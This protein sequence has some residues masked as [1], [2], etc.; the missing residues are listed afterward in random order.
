MADNLAWTPGAGATIAT[1]EV[2]TGGGNAHVQLIKL[3]DGTDG[4]TERIQGT[5]A[6][7]LEV[8]VTRVQG[9]VTVAGTVSVTNTTASGLQA[10]VVGTVAH[11][12]AD[13]GKPVKFGLKANS[14]MPAAV[15][16]GQRVDAWGDLYGRQV[17]VQNHPT[18]SAAIAVATAS[19]LTALIASSTGKIILN[20][21]SIHNRNATGTVVQLVDGSSTG[22]AF[23]KGLL[24]SGGGGSLFDFGAGKSLTTGNALYAHIDT[25]GNVD[26][27]LTEYST[28]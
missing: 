24:A 27:N 9:S 11:G 8:D 16:S 7:G 15:S 21:G 1:D 2:N 5:A 26:F 20:K 3:L 25:T 4:G 18:P 28:L 10:E 19:G 22:N 6:N 14:T 13:S 17:V 23:W 12:S